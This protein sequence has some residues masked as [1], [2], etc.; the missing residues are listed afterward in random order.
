MNIVRLAVLQKGRADRTGFTLIELL[1]VI[2]IIMLLVVFILI[3]LHGQ[4]QKAN[5]AKRKSSLFV[6]HN[7]IEEYNNDHGIF[8]PQDSVT[9]C[10]GPGLAPYVNQIPCDPVTRKPYGYFISGATGGYRVCAIL[11]N[12]TDPAIAAMGCGGPAKCG[13]PGGFN[14]CLSSGAP[15]S[16]VG[17]ADQGSSGGY[18]SAPPGGG[19]GGGGGGGQQVNS[20]ACAPPDSNGVSFCNYYSDPVG[21]GCP[22][23]FIERTCNNECQ[24]TPAVRCNQ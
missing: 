14:Y 13:V 24:S 1:I 8:P 6:L 10:G 11:E 21:S 12:L 20:W 17:T 2:T 19:G 23:T 22:V 5:D 18:N 16:A 15:P 4:I 7:G 3:S 9:G